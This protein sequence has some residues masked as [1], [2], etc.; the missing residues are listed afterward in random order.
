LGLISVSLHPPILDPALTVHEFLRLHT[1]ICT[2]IGI[3]DVV[4]RF[5]LH[6]I[7]DIGI[8]ELSSGQRK[9]LD[10]TRVFNCL[11]RNGVLLLDEPSESLDTASRSLLIDLISE[12]L[13]TV[14][15]VIVSTHDEIFA[16]ELGKLGV[17]SYVMLDNG[18]AHKVSFGA[19]STG[20]T[21]ALGFK[22]SSNY[23]ITLTV[24]A[25][26]HGRIPVS[27]LRSITGVR[28]VDFQPDI[29]WILQRLGLDRSSLNNVIMAT[30]GSLESNASKYSTVK[31]DSIMV[32]FSIKAENYD[33]LARALGKLVEYGRVEYLNI[34][35]QR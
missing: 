21:E 6:S 32:K 9:R 2:G 33:A 7:A 11:P 8:Y 27:E 10:L 34:G 20:S 1:G 35:D 16:K 25:L 3:K 4:N 17:S 28:S 19:D 22:V 24:K 18:K 23:G 15:A 29:D 14:E 13:N 31:L 12:S 30:P 5:D 26:I